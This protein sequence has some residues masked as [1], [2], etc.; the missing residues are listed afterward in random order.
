LGAGFTSGT[1]WV[2]SFEGKGWSNSV[3]VAA[4]PCVFSSAR[5][6]SSRAAV[7]NYDELTIVFLNLVD[8]AIKYAVTAG[9][10]RRYRRSGRAAVAVTSEPA[11]GWTSDG[12]PTPC[13]F[14]RWPSTERQKSQQKNWQRRSPQLLTGTIT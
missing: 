14:Y 10:R 12:V 8:N 5:A 9:R 7:G 13:E 6:T 4:A 2:D 11:T 1:Q 3:S